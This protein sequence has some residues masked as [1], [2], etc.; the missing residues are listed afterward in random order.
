VLNYNKKNTLLY[1]FSYILINEILPLEAK[2]VSLK[3]YKN[4]TFVRKVIKFYLNE[5]FKNSE[6]LLTIKEFNNRYKKEIENLLLDFKVE[7]VDL[8]LKTNY[9]NTNKKDIEQYFYFENKTPYITKD[10]IDDLILKLETDLGIKNDLIKESQLKISNID[11]HISSEI[12]KKDLSL[13]KEKIKKFHKYYKIL[14]YI[15][16]KKGFLSKL[17]EKEIQP[18][19]KINN[20]EYLYFV[21]IHEFWNFLAHFSM[22]IVYFN[23]PNN[24]LSNLNKSISHLKRAIMDLL[25]GMIIEY[26]CSCLP[27]YLK[28]RVKKIASLG[29]RIRIQELIE[30]LSYIFYNCENL[31]PILKEYEQINKN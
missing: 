17:D 22:G 3:K 11:K 6:E 10:R 4:F 27:E 21:V 8:L 12:Y 9:L 7:Y 24:F 14:E 19:D 25:D 28:L 15:L 2:Y 23:S 16:N 29:N 31:K 30:D 18:I 5:I 26:N 20:L 13:L 1:N